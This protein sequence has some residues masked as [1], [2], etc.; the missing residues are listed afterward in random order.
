MFQVDTRHFASDALEDA[1]RL[2][3]TKALNSYT[4][5]DCLSFLNYAWS[6]IYSR[7]ANIDDGYYGT[8]VKLT[9][10]L[11]R[12]P[13]FVKNSIQVYSAQSPVGYDRLVYRDAGATDMT[14]SGV[15]KISGNDLYCPDA[16]RKSVWLY[17]VPACPQ[18]FFTH[19]NRDPKL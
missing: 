11:T 7:M 5:S 4:F 19:H 17:Y 13:P 9:N 3:Q 18:V 8:N 10:K 2:A 6:D 14:S 16:E 1:M 15:Y 12:L